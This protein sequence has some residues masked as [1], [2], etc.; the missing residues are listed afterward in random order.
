MRLHVHLCISLLGL[1]LTYADVVYFNRNAS[2]GVNI[3]STVKSG[4]VVFNARDTVSVD[5]K[6]FINP[7]LTFSSYYS[8][9]FRVR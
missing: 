5:R 6:N 8:S 1:K 7:V 9:L 3:S 4:G 2:R